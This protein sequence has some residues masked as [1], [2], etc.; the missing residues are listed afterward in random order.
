MDIRPGAPL[1]ESC[2]SLK[3]I[4]SSQLL[5]QGH[6]RGAPAAWHLKQLIQRVFSDSRAEVREIAQQQEEDHGVQEPAN[7]GQRCPEPGSRIVT[8]E[9]QEREDRAE[10]ADCGNDHERIAIERIDCR[11]AQDERSDGS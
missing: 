6:G 4:G 10:K 7:E 11:W 3:W 1:E 8:A 9:E 5:A 2:E